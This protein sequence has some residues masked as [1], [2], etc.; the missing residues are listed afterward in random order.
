MGGESSHRAAVAKT[1]MSLFLVVTQKAE[2][3]APES[4]K[5]IES[6]VSC[7]GGHL[8]DVHHATCCGM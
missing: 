3:Q 2:K 1:P 6:C 7:A 5:E 4:T 8:A